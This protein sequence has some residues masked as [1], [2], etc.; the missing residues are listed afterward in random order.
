MICTLNMQNKQTTVKQQESA[1]STEANIQRWKQQKPEHYQYYM[2]MFVYM[3][4][5]VQIMKRNKFSLQ[6]SSSL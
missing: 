3:D 2:K 6:K 5:C 1:V 4:L